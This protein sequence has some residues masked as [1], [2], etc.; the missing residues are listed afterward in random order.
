MTQKTDENN[1]ERKEKTFDEVYNERVASNQNA[2]ER[3]NIVA[4]KLKSKYE[5]YDATEAFVEYLSSIERIFSRSEKENWSVERTQDEMIKGEIYIM[6][7]TT[8]IDEEIF[9]SIYEEFKATNNNVSKIQEIANELMKK[10]EAVEDC[11]ECE[12]CRKFIMYVKESLLMFQKTLS[13]N[14]SFDELDEVKAASIK[15]KMN[16]MAKDGK[17]PVEILQNIYDDFMEGI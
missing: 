10:Y 15:I 3:V 6:S 9:N 4:E 14:S 5:E 7:Q 2:M 1:M 11:F 8:G 13:G 16:V 17:P 12:D